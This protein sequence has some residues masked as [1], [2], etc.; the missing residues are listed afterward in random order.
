MRH[1]VR[2]DGGTST[3]ALS[4]ARAITSLSDGDEQYFFFVN[5]GDGQKLERQLQKHVQVIE[6]VS[7]PPTLARRI[8]RNIPFARAIWRYLRN[9]PKPD[10]GAW[11]YLLAHSDETLEREN[12]DVVHFTNQWGFLTDIPFIYHPHD[13]Q[14]RH[15][16]E[17][18]TPADYRFREV[19]YSELCERASA[20]SV[21]SQWVKQ[22]LLSNFNLV[23]SKIRVVHFAPE[24]QHCSQVDT[25]A[26]RQIGKK[27][28]LPLRFIFYPAR[29]WPHKNHLRLFQALKLLRDDRGLTVPLVCSG[30]PT[31]FYARL[32]DEMRA[33]QLEDQV[34]F[35]GFVDSDE[36]SALFRLCSAV[37][38][39]T[40]FEAGSFPLWEAFLSE[41]PAA[42]SNVTSL[43][44]QA[45]NSALIFDPCKV[46][47]IAKAIEKL[48]TDST[49]CAFLVAEGSANISRY[50]WETTARTFR[51]LY[52]QLGQ[53]QLTAEDHALLSAP[54]LM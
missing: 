25:E 5:S 43:P 22:D 16:P 40:L 14:H 51:A 38:I 50:S 9:T 1:A 53:R 46:E 28:S 47:E 44:A 15:L 20:V 24:P 21:V 2:S 35:V 29:T 7:N 13:L 41:K 17:F 6:S 36:L 48:W 4:L 19:M 39:P 8:A 10:G 30:A 42:C 52:R 18:F 34:L 49:L 54:P 3:F 33:L 31:E 11:N 26:V 12:I 23:E 32:S 45:G 27:L 37:I